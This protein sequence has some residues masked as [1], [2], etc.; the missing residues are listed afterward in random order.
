MFFGVR[1]AADLFHLERL[2]AI[3]ERMPSVEIAP[4]LSEPGPAGPT[5]PGL[6]TDAVD[7]RLPRLSGCDATCAARRR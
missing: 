5:R 7:R 6:V 2:E 4:V 3:G 1:A